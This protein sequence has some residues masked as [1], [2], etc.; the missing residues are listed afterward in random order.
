MNK[1]LLQSSAI[2][3]ILLALYYFG[4][5]YLFFSSLHKQYPILVAFFFLQSLMIS[6]LL[7]RGR[8]KNWESPVYT[9]GTVVLRLFTGLI[10]LVV[11]YV[12]KIDDLKSLMLQFIVLY[13]VYLIFELFTVLSNLRRN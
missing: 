10:F 4:N 13:L 2:S 5:E 11:L 3:L 8:K 12:K 1:Y 6:R 9:L 7:E